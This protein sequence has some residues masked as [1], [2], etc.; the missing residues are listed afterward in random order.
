MELYNGDCFELLARLP[1]KSVDMVLTD[2]PYNIGK[3][4]WDKIDDYVAWCGKWFKECERVLKDTG[5]LVWWH[6]QVMTS[7]RLLMW[8]DANTEF[9]FNSVGFWHKPRFRKLSWVNVGGRYTGRSFFNIFEW[10]FVFAKSIGGRSATGR[11]MINSNAA[12]YRP[13]KDWYA[14]ECER[15]GLNNKAIGEA[16]TAHTGRKPYMLRH[17]FHD[18]QF[19][20]PTQNV[21]EGVY[22]PLGFGKTYEE[23]R[24][25]Y[26]ELRAEY[27]GLRAEHEGLR[28]PFNVEAGV[29]CSNYFITNDNMLQNSNNSK[30]VHPCQKPVDVLERLI[31]TYTNEGALVLDPF[32]G[33][34]STGVACANTGREFIGME[35][36]E[37]FCN[38]AKSR[39]DEAFLMR[40]NS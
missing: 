37:E 30:R 16:Y 13:L 2:P 38:I 24:A 10:F 23:L 34:G 39:I 35:L 4:E 19:E 29:P 3:G 27:E 32:M 25:E 20:I 36:D 33:S 40:E 1:D 22:M 8:Q 18:S 7:A 11:E 14:D 12:C 15:L 17:Y 26:E 5:V 9:V 31:K 6:N 21:W 28:T